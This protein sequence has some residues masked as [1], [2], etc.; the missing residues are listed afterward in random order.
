LGPE[1]LP[2]STPS[3]VRHF[4]PVSEQAVSDTEINEYISDADAQINQE[5]GSFT[6]SVPRR[7]QR[8]SA[9]LAAKDILNR[10]DVAVD[11]STGDFSKTQN[12]QELIAILE[13][14][15]DKIYRYDYR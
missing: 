8:L 12:K 13:R 5:I 3:D 14:Q 7:I 15:I 6:E 9:L 4:A 1:H 2:Y 10:P 11:F